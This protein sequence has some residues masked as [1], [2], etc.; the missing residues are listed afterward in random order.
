LIVGGFLDSELGRRVCLEAFIRDEYAAADRAAV[1]AVVDPLESPIDRSEPVP[2][3]G[4]HSVVDTLL[5]QR[6]GRIRRIAF[7]LMVI[8]TSRAEIRQQL[9]HLRTFGVQ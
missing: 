9:L 7:G 1:A 3:T 8:G 6:L 5:R 2:Q 4:G